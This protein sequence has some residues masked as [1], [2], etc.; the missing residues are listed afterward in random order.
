M[1]RSCG[2]KIRLTVGLQTQFSSSWLRT[3]P[4]FAQLVED[5]N[6]VETTPFSA[7]CGLKWISSP[8]TSD[9]MNRR[10]DWYSPPLAGVAL[11]GRIVGWARLPVPSAT[12]IE[13]L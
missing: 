5:R 8:T 10:P 4:V 7:H 2:L 12:A 13:L 9:W 11:V 6:E 3:A 1:S